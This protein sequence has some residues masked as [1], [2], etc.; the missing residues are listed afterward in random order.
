MKN[1]PAPLQVIAQALV[2]W[3]DAWI[4]MVIVNLAWILCWLTIVL[5]PPAT[6]G[7][8]HVTNRLAH[9]ENLGLGGLIEGGRRY[10]VQ[11]WLWMLLN[12]SVAIVI[13][14]DLVFYT[15]IEAAWVGFLQGTFVI[16]SLFWLM[17]QFYAPPYLMEQD[18]KSLKLTLRN[19]A[20]TVLAAPGYTIVVA[21][22]A[23][24]LI[25]FS[26][27]LVFPLFMG[28]PC[29][30]A[31]IGNRAVMERMETYGVREREEGD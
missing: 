31:V 27:F 14:V 5:G 7:L 21:G 22:V 18:N 30:I 13:A 28:I 23:A 20:F 3:W 4:S 26:L 8:Y 25:V 9:G 16:L 1:L 6:F 17:V 11:S 24:L 19:G 15:Q 29:L 12:L 10:F 2:D